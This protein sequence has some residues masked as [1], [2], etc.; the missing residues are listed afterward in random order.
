MVSG[1]Q[2]TYPEEILEFIVKRIPTELTKV[3]VEIWNNRNNGGITWTSLVKNIGDRYLVEKALL[4]F[5]T[6]GFVIVE[7]S[8][9][10][11]RQKNYQPHEVRGLQLAKYLQQQVRTN[12]N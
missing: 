11:R 2:I 5:E 8:T 3:F 10:D 9:V 6:N 12:S 1:N 7:S 4:L